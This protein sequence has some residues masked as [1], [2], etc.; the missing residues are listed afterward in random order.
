M[1]VTTKPSPV[2]EDVPKQ[3]PTPP[4]PAVNLD[5]SPSVIPLNS[6][7]TLPATVSE[8]QDH[9]DQDTIELV[10]ITYLKCTIFC[11]ILCV[12]I[13]FMCEETVLI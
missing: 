1:T 9:V 13:K 4:S 8:L 12:L 5:G 7:D 11:H 10:L 2:G 6:S 3:M